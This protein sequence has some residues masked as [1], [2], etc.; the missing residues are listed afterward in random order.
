[1]HLGALPA[2]RPDGE[3]RLVD[4]VAAFARAAKDH[5]QRV[6]HQLGGPRSPLSDGEDVILDVC[7]SNRLELP[8]IKDR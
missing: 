6:Q 5:L 4:D 3:H 2:G 1:V 7:R 8:G